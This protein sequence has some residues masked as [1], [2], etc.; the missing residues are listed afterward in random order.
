MQAGA[1]VG[2]AVVGTILSSF[3]YCTLY[4]FN[5]KQNID[6]KSVSG[7]TFRFRVET[8]SLTRIIIGL[9]IWLNPRFTLS[10][11]IATLIVIA[12]TSTFT[13]NIWNR[14][15]TTC[16]CYSMVRCLLNDFLHERAFMYTG[17]ASISRVYGERSDADMTLIAYYLLSRLIFEGE[18]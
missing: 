4:L 11:V 16:R 6:D 9:S 2:A 12:M 3:W 15:M 1:V 13:R 5:F 18:I 7:T 10:E 8:R 14:D 17:C